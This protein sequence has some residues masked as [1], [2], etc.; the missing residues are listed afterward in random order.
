MQSHALSFGGWFARRQAA[1]SR[2]RQAFASRRSRATERTAERTASKRGALTGGR[3]RITVSQRRVP[4]RKLR[5]WR[6]QWAIARSLARALLARDSAVAT[7]VVAVTV[8]FVVELELAPLLD[9]AAAVAAVAMPANAS[10]S[11]QARMKRRNALPPQGRLQVGGRAG[12]IDALDEHRS[13]RLMR[14]LA[15]G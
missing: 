2:C 7:V 3:P 4:A 15:R 6:F 5:R 9:P 11:P 1:C 14:S 8:V 12:G 13:A 10:R